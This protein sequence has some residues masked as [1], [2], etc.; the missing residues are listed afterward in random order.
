VREQMSDGDAARGD[1]SGVKV[2]ICGLMRREDVEVA[3]RAGADYV[4][5]ILSEGFRRSVAAARAAALVQGVSP[6]PVAVIVD[7]TP[8]SAEARA[9]TLGAGVIQLHGE[10]APDVVRELRRRGAWSMWKSVRVGEPDDV[11]RAVDLYGDLVQGL[12]LEG[13]RPGVVGGGGVRLDLDGLER[14]LLEVPSALEIILAGGL[15]AD[16]VGAV[17]ARFRPRVVDVSS[18]VEHAL[19]RKDPE[20]VRRFVR[21]AR[22]SS[23]SE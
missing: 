7:A 23:H 18:G 4:G 12:L 15:T 13:F 9:T 5:I 10:E 11:T 16:N 17:V 14:A 8:D 20:L 19:G 2:K 3:E 6:T 22:G 1:R 21:S